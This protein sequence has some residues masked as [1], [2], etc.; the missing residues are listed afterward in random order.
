[1][2]SKSKKGK[3]K[4]TD[5]RQCHTANNL[6]KDLPSIPFEASEPLAYSNPKAHYHIASS[7]RYFLNVHQWL[8]RHSEDRALEGFLPRL[9]DHLLARILGHQY[10]GD[11]TEFSATQ[12]AQVVFVNDRIFRHKVLRINYTTYDLRRAQD[13]LNPR[14]HA[15]VMVLAHEDDHPYW[16]AWILGVFHVNVVYTGNDTPSFNSPQQMDFVWVRWFGRDPNNYQ[17]GWKVKRLHRLGFIPADEPGAFGFLDPRHL[18]RGVHL[19]P[20]FA[21]GR[22]DG[23]LPPSIARLLHE[24]N[25]DWKFY[26]VNM[27]VDRD[28]F[29]R[30]RGGGV[31]HR[32]TRNAT[33]TFCNDR[34]PLD[35]VAPGNN[36]DSE[37]GE[38][39]SEEDKEAS[40]DEVEASS[41]NEESSAERQL[42]ASEEYEDDGPPL[43]EDEEDGLSESAVDEG[44]VQ[45]EVVESE[46][47]EYGYGGL[48][49]EE[50]NTDEEADA[51]Q[52]DSGSDNEDNDIDNDLGPEDGEDENE[53][54]LEGYG[55]L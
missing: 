6:S 53:E 48:D 51:D 1:M 28:M 15:D 38:G 49:Q 18:I 3:A 30:F 8:G 12:R 31:G 50:E 7:T 45:D 41:E 27:F 54:E 52:D 33:Q 14:T 16:Y 29:M 2:P 36:A 9:K 43:E 13:S 17:S 37:Q 44:I 10:D 47:E 42:E 23:L 55:E 46:M 26:Y 4:V 21:Y 25:E 39:A 34:D 20:A 5:K 35:C 11:E 32:S 40:E 22:T 19:I 24:N